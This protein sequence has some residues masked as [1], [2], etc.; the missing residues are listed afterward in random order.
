MN[1]FTN[2]GGFDVTVEA[3][4]LPST[5]QACIDTVVFGGGVVLIGVSRQTLDFNFTLIQKKELNIFGSRNAFKRD[6][7]EVINLIKD[8][9]MPIDRI[10]TNTYH[11]LDAE[12][13]L[14]DF[15]TN[16]DSMLKVVLDFT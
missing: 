8:G 4:G 2:G 3:V 15:D 1:E 6:F 11:W 9:D 12:S 10:V 13:A 16:S 7:L 14:K 5:F